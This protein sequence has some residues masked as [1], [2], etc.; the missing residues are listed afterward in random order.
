[1]PV[2]RVLARLQYLVCGVLL[3][4]A[5]PLSVAQVT[6]TGQ[7][8]VQVQPDYALFK[9]AVVN[10]GESLVP[11]REK[12]Q[13]TVARWLA[14]AKELGMSQNDLATTPAMTFPSRWQCGTCTEAEQK[15]GFTAR[16]E[17]TFTLRRINLLATL[18]NELSTDPTVMLM[19]VEYHT[20]A[21]RQYRDQARAMAIRAAR[22]KAQALAR[23]LGQDIGAATSINESNDLGSGFWS[24]SQ[25]G[26]SC[27]G[28]YRSYGQYGGGGFAQ[29]VMS[30]APSS[31]EPNEG[32]IAPGMIPVRASVSVVFELTR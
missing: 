11:T 6:V 30:V 16:S 3:V 29:N 21:L 28:Y 14:R 12:N 24:W 13:A 22:E 5:A 7:A 32:A 20:S 31:G 4:L 2:Q 8:E 18:A 27:C 23:E 17:A 9:L 15:T 19:D 10:Y 26:Y 1:M 25:W